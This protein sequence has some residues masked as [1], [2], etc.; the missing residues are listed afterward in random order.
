MGN[1]LIDRPKM[2]VERDQCPGCGHAAFTV[3]AR[4]PFESPPFREYFAKQYEGRADLGALAGANYELVR[5]RHCGLGYQRTIPGPALLI[6][7]YERW[8]PQSEKERLYNEY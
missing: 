6:E 7:L 3:L 8:L 5:C 1:S 2:L 4:E